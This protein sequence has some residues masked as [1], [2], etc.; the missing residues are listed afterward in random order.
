VKLSLSLNWHLNERNVNHHQIN[1]QQKIIG[2]FNGGI[3]LF[4][5]NKAL[6]IN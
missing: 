1:Q 6:T 2:G 3:K 5:K 4:T